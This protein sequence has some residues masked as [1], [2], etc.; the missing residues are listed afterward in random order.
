M[1]VQKKINYFAERTVSVSEGPIEHTKTFLG[2][3]KNA[4][5]FVGALQ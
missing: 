3:T 1:D 4:C 2:K 5:G